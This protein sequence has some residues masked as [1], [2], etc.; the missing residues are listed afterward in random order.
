MNREIT[1]KTNRFPQKWRLRSPLGGDIIK[2]C[3]LRFDKGYY[4]VDKSSVSE[5]LNK[6][7]L[8]LHGYCRFDALADNLLPCR[9]LSRL[10]SAFCLD[11]P[12]LL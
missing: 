1:Q 11:S 4:M 10:E 9:A 3:I 2:V 5:I 7:S 8:P 12:K 6:H